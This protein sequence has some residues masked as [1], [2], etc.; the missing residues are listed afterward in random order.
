MVNSGYEDAKRILK[1]NMDVLHSMANALLEYETIDSE[2]VNLLVKGSSLDEI[3]KRRGELQK[4]LEEERKIAAS[5]AK[6]KEILFSLHNVTSL[7]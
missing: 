6:E 5:E 1:E 3:K 4:E 7:S 2:E